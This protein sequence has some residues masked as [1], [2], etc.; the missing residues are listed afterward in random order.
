MASSYFLIH[1][2][3]NNEIDL[4]GQNQGKVTYDVTNNCEKALRVRARAVALEGTQ[5]AWLSLEGSE[6]FDLA[7][8]GTSQCSVKIALPPGTPA[9]R[10]QFRLDIASVEEPQEVYA[11]G[12]RVAAVFKP[13][14]KDTPKGFPWWILIVAAAVLLVMIGTVVWL[15]RRKPG[16]GGPPPNPKEFSM[17]LLRQKNVVDALLDMQ[18]KKLELGSVSG[19]P[20]GDAGMVTEQNPAWEAKVKEGDKVD[21]VVTQGVI[22]TSAQRINAINANYRKILEDNKILLHVPV[23]ITHPPGVPELV[24]PAPGAR[25]S[26]LP[27]EFEVAWKPATGATSYAVEVEYNQGGWKPLRLPAAVTGT[28]LKI[29]FPAAHPGRWRVTAITATGARGTPSDW[30]EFLY[31]K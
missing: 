1:A 8:K 18:D 10:Y 9:G 24:S 2:G 6:E 31:E 25:M 23:L 3:G 4:K 5:Q 26:K 29:D 7:L 19:K 13:I 21:L 14:P 17:P 20:G 12:Q 11:E 22:I 30:R 16:D 28:S 15:V 27:R